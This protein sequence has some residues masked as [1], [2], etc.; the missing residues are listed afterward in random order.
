[1]HIESLRRTRFSRAGRQRCR[2][3]IRH[4]A[5]HRREEENRQ[6]HRASGSREARRRSLAQVARA[7]KTGKLMGLL[8]GTMSLRYYRVEGDLP[9]D[10]RED[11]LAQ[12]KK[13]G[14]REL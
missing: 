13:F 1:M 6:E 5:L 7:R 11:F 10:Y 9:K 4:A 2:G 14:F 12:M 8:N 3:A